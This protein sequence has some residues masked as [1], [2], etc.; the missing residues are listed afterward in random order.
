MARCEAAALDLWLGDEP[1]DRPRDDWLA[2]RMIERRTL[3]RVTSP[4][5]LLVDLTL[6][7]E[8]F[9]FE[10]VWDARRVTRTRYSSLPTWMRCSSC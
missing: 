5:E 1:L 9:D 6:V 7:M 4:N 10:T 3:T 8:G 2:E